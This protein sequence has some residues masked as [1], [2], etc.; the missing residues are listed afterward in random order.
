MGCLLEVPEP[1][2]LGDRQARPTPVLLG[3]GWEPLKAVY[4]NRGFHFLLLLYLTNMP[5]RAPR[6]VGSPRGHGT[7][8]EPRTKSMPS[9]PADDIHGSH[10]RQVCRRHELY[11]SFQD[12]GWLVS[13]LLSCLPSASAPGWVSGEEG[14]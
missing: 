2:R 12:L 3:R 14:G 4:E 6:T 9:V 13:R 10:G 5:V 11:V 7:E 8:Q 1:H